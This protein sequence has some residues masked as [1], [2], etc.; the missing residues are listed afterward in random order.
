LL[1]RHSAEDQQRMI[2]KRHNE[3]F[4]HHTIVLAKVAL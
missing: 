3:G 2:A 4:F 1:A